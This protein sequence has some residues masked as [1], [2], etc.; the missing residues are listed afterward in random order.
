MLEELHQLSAVLQVN[1]KNWHGGREYYYTYDPESSM[2]TPGTVSFAP[3]W[4]E[5]G[6][7]VS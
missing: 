4:F 5:L 7:D 1:N 3:A 2:L 6:H